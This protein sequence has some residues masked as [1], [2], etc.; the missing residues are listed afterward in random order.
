VV[1]RSIVDSGTPRR[2]RFRVAV[3]VALAALFLPGAASAHPTT[4]VVALDYQT[5]VE[6]A[7]AGVSAVVIDG[8]RRLRLTVASGLRVS[9]LG[10]AGEPFLRFSADGV[11]AN[12]RS[13][14]AISTKVV[15]TRSGQT[16]VFGGAAEW[17][18]VSG[19]RSFTWHDHRL[20][21]SLPRG[22]RRVAWS[23]PLLVDGRRVEVGGVFRRFAKPAL[24]PW[25]L[26]LG[27]C[28]AAGAIGFAGGEGR[29][30]RLTIALAA[31]AGGAALVSVAG[32]SAG[33]GVGERT[34]LLELG[35]S[36]AL[37][38]AAA[39]GLAFARRSR[40]AVAGGIALLALIEGLGRLGV[41][42]HAVVVSALPA[43][44]TRG[45]D[46]I[47]IAA[48]LVVLT[49]LLTR[50]YP[51]PIRRGAGRTG[52]PAWWL[53]KLAPQAIRSGRKGTR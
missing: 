29:R 22:A 12:A 49:L 3:V 6:H 25:L 47:A 21:P 24:W 34:K 48:G 45:V 35:A 4:A 15:A 30:L 32:F 23:V 18:R 14:T 20:A 53:S 50:P 31:A 26:V 38:L 28:F 1:V 16:P 19:G 37:G 13:V 41:F 7:P 9:V 33:N 51:K 2:R 44:L 52:R 43:A 39:L 46:T 11:F 36:G 17:R 5:T 40:V 27:A 42:F 8:D 10:F